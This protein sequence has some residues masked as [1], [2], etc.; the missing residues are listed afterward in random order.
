VTVLVLGAAVSGVAAARLARRLGNEVVAYDRSDEAVTMLREEGFPV[1]SGAWDDR[2]LEGVDRVVASPGFPETSAPIQRAL[3]AGI[4]VVSELEFG[5]LHLPAP[6]VAVT[7][8]NGKTTITTVITD[9]LNASGVTA[10]AAG[11]IGTP[12]CDLSASAAS[13]FVLEASSF[14][15]RFIDRFHPVAAGIVNIAADH[16][17]WHGTAEAY[18]RAK[19]RIF[20]NMSGED[21]IVYNADDDGATAAIATATCATMP[22]SGVRVPEGGAGPSGDALVIGGRRHRVASTDPTWMVDLVM[23]AVIAGAVGATE[24]GIGSVLSSF[25]SGEHRRRVV[26]RID[27]VAWIDDSKATNPHAARAAASAYPSVI[28]LAG[29]RNKNLDLSTV[30]PDTVRH[31]VAFGEA[32]PEVAGAVDRPVTVVPDLA[33]AVEA[34]ARIARPGDT[35]L[36]APGCASFDEFESYAARGDRF[37]NL[38]EQTGAAK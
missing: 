6:Y 8:T 29:G 25:H 24:E 7:G 18:A 10:V 14:Q 11:N 33:G 22:V 9:M 4:P 21:L 32:G 1:H 23:S 34:A 17:D 19:A 3:A 27:G 15:L 2:S 35:V 26:A 13:V 5:A 16:L 28:L 12:V 36:L 30:A 31:V 20:T 38:V 37:A